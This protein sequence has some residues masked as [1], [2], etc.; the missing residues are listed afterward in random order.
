VS[1]AIW[2]TGPGNGT[3]TLVQATAAQLRA[4]GEPVTVLELDETRSRPGPPPRRGL[5]RASCV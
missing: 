1:W 4:L 2:I 3:S 5:A